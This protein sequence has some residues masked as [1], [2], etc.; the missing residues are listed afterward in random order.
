MTDHK[1]KYASL[2]EIADAIDLL[3]D[4]WAAFIE[5]ADYVDAHVRARYL[6]RE[7]GLRGAA[8]FIRQCEIVP[9]ENTP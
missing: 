8:R 6:Q 2:D 5:S 9:K 3:A 4:N 1:L 7:I